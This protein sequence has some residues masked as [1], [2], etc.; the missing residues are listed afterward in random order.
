MNSSW[1][2]KTFPKTK[3]IHGQ[4]TQDKFVTTKQGFR[5]AT[6]NRSSLTGEGADII[7]LDDPQNPYNISIEKNNEFI[8]WYK[9]TLISRLNNRNQG[10]IIIATHRIAYND[11]SGYLLNKQRNLWYQA[12]IPYISSKNSI[13]RI[14][15]FK[16]KYKKN[17]ILNSKKDNKETLETL[18]KE[19]GYINFMTQFQQNP[20]PSQ[21]N[22]I[23]P[24][25]LLHYK[26]LSQ[27]KLE[28]EYIIQSW[29]TSNKTKIN[30]DYSVSTTWAVIKNSV[31]LLDVYRKKLEYPKLK[32]ALLSL[33]QK[34]QPSAIL[35]EDKSS[36]QSLIQDLKNH[37]NL[38]IIPINSTTN[39]QHRLI[40]AAIFIESAK[41]FIPEHSSWL[42]EYI[43]EL[44]H[45]PNVKH[46]DQV[47]STS[48]FLNWF[49]QRHY[50]SHIKIRSLQ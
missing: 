40:S 47:D 2:K 26:E 18:R 34:W 39:K 27:I 25:W 44:I 29:D 16:Y 32:Q 50:Q 23:N 10:I 30:N 41:M 3:I 22:V 4:N 38:N 20:L 37:H 36:G 49:N 31:Y 12:S 28:S 1:Y 24:K 46:D 5:F 33:Q 19:L 7:I 11:L 14:N 17:E 42:E 35:I 43:Q 15:D 45:F 9:N 8:N 48:Q 21:S 13:Y 6:S